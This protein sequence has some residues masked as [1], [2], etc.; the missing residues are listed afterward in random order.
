M[1]PLRHPTPLVAPV[2]YPPQAPPAAADAGLAR[3]STH[4]REYVRSG[5]RKRER[6]ELIKLLDADGKRTRNAHTMPLRIQVLRS[7]LPEAVRMQIFEDLRGGACD[8]YV[9]WVRRALRL[10]LG[11]IASTP[12]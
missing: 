5:L 12:P 3:L 7:G 1:P 2:V 11:R 6:T 9:Q 10:P 8:K 4:E